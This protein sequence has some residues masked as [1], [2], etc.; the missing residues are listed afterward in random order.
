MFWQILSF[1]WIVKPRL[2]ELQSVYDA[3]LLFTGVSISPVIETCANLP[4]Y[5]SKYSGRSCHGSCQIE[6]L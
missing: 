1:P 5:P 2:A 4:G 6:A 3:E